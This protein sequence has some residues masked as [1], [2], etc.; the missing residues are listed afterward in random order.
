[1][2]DPWQ[3]KTSLIYFTPLQIPLQKWHFWVCCL[4]FLWGAALWFTCLAKGKRSVTKA[5]CH[6]F[7]LWFIRTVS[8]G[9]S[10]KA[11][12]KAE[13]KTA[14]PWWKRA[15]FAHSSD[16]CI[17]DTNVPQQGQACGLHPTLG[18]VINDEHCIIKSTMTKPAYDTAHAETNL[19]DKYNKGKHY[20]GVNPSVSLQ[21]SFKLVPLHFSS[22]PSFA[23]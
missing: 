8:P 19:M 23:L 16:E 5:C 20:F 12:G 11:K 15:I 4:T 3:T 22:R 13:I 10:F 17:K 6:T 14:F 9:T 18:D 1:M 21:L 2:N 7:V